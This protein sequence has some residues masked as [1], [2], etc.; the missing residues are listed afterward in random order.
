[1]K[2]ILIVG[3]IL[4]ITTLFI[5]CGSKTK[6]TEAYTEYIGQAKVE[7]LNGDYDNG[8]SI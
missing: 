7:I 4:G 6:V 3:I 8:V 2:K 5:G 1:M